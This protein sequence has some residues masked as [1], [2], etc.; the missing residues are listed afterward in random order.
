MYYAECIE[1]TFVCLIRL[2]LSHV[3]IFRSRIAF[4]N[5]NR[6]ETGTRRRAFLM[7]LFCHP[8]NIFLQAFHELCKITTFN[9]FKVFMH[10]FLY[11]KKIF[12]FPDSLKHLR[13]IMNDETFNQ[14]DAL[15]TPQED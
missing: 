10:A 3:H 9:I 15:I 5:L 4:Y 12:R 7:K 6:D 2:K 11:K 13:P 1:F 14:F 8:R